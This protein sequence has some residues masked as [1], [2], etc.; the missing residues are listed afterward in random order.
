MYET[1]FTDVKVTGLAA[2]SPIPVCKL[3]DFVPL[4]GSKVVKRIKKATGIKQFRKSVKRQTASDLDVIAA[5]KILADKGIDRSQIGAVINITQTPDYKTPATAFVI[6]KRLNLP[7]HCIAFDVNLGCTGYVYGLFLAASILH[8]SFFKYVLLTVGDAPKRYDLLRRKNPDHTYLMMFGDAGTATLLEKT[9]SASKM[10]TSLRADGTD[11]AMIHTIG[12]TRCLDVPRDIRVGEDGKDWSYY[13]SYMDGMG[14]FSFSTKVVPEILDE[15]MR[16][17]SIKMSEIDGFYL[18]QANKTIIDIIARL[19]NLPSDKVHLSLDRYG[20][21]SCGSIPVTIVDT[22]GNCNSKI[23]QHIM[24]CGFG[25]GLSW[26]I[27]MVD[28]SP[29]DIYPMIFSDDYYLDGDLGLPSE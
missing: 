12:G 20:N 29:Q 9:N 5:E 22:L 23:N 13:D 18:H 6:H 11:F 21:T 3:E 1:I 15:F 7:E 8:S 19:S 27:A 10:I 16:D 4:V 2:A 24:L 14:V 26:G 17:N 25:I 28:I